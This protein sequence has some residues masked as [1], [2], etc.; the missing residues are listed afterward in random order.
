MQPFEIFKRD[1]VFSRNAVS[2]T[3]HVV[4]GGGI[5]ILGH[6]GKVSKLHIYIYRHTDIHTYIRM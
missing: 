6:E 5:G 1:I 2:A 3:L 4:D